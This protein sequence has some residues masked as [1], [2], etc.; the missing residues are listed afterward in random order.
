[1]DL[2][3]DPEACKTLGVQ[4]ISKKEGQ[5]LA[6]KIGAYAYF[7]CSAKLQVGLGELFEGAVAAV[8]EPT[9][10]MS[11]KELKKIDEV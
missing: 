9:K 5:D 6:K 3:D 10:L 8:V 2:R 7:E 4:P 11:E 1:M